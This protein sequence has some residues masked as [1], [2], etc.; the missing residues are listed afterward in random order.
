MYNYR[1]MV[2]LM[3]IV[4]ISSETALSDDD[5]KQRLSQV[6]ERFADQRSID[7][8]VFDEK[9]SIRDRSGLCVMDVWFDE[10]LTRQRIVNVDDS[11]SSVA[12]AYTAEEWEAFKEKSRTGFQFDGSEF[13]H[14]DCKWRPGYVE[15]DTLKVT[16]TAFRWRP[17]VAGTLES[18]PMVFVEYDNP[19]PGDREGYWTED[20][21]AWKKHSGGLDAEAQQWLG[22]W[23]YVYDGSEF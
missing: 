22:K 23:G 13:T 10:T 6:E 7:P 11:C 14:L 1:F 21:S 19:T 20:D 15:W 8:I 3:G 9:D 12:D 5:L 2:P 17:N 16:H 18:T 4:Y